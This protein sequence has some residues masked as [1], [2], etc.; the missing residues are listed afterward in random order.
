MS[1]KAII[2]PSILSCDFAALG[3]ECNRVLSLGADWCHVDVM[4]GH[5]VPNLTLGAPIIECLHKA[6]SGFLDVHLMVD[7]P[8][9]YVESFAKA[10]ATQFNFHI[11]ATKNADALIDRI[12]QAGMKAAIAIK[13]KTD[14]STVFPYLSK[15]DMVLVMTVEPGFGGQ[16]FM[17]D[18]LEKVKIL[19]Q[20]CPELNIQVDGGINLETI[21]NAA[22]AGANVIVAGAIF[23][24]DK[25]KEMIEQFRTVVNNHFQ[26]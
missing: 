14:V 23:R 21:H 20:K 24:T 6:C 11:E 5:F 1:V 2:A 19:R 9:D 26:K 16:S 12:H 3:Q 22:E 7:N 18:M 13:P 4:D 17:F 15:L 10:G 8:G 25:P